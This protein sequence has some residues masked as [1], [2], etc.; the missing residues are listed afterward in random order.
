MFPRLISQHNEPSLAAV[1]A[2]GMLFN[3]SWLAIVYSHSP[4]Y[5]PAI[6]LLHLLIHFALMGRGVVEVRLI[7]VVSLLGFS[8][9]QAIFAAGV[10]TASG[11]YSVAPTWISCLWPV[12]ATTLMHAFSSLQKRLILAAIIGAVGGT[13]SY[14][15]GARMSDVEFVSQFWGPIT[16]AL[17]WAIVFPSIL[18]ATRLNAESEL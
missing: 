12:L 14:L 18:L 8:L 16:M 17:V 15:A 1:I 5:A 7:F 9:D 3:A 4:L 10:L 2:N 13:A 6:A 11:P